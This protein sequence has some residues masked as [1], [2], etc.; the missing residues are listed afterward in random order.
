M[1]LDRGV[2]FIANDGTI[3]AVNYCHNI[4]PAVTIEIDLGHVHFPNLIGL[5]RLTRSLF[6]LDYPAVFQPLLA[7]TQFIHNP[8]NSF[9]TDIYV[10]FASEYNANTAIA[11][12]GIAVTG[13][14]DCCG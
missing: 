3:I 2:D 12:K 8:V 14:F 6:H 13:H 1:A 4:E 10:K 5:S 11:I 9:L 7:Q